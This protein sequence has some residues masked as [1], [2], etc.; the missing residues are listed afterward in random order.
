[1]SSFKLIILSGTAPGLVAFLITSITQGCSQC[2]RINYTR[3]WSWPLSVFCDLAGNEASL[4]SETLR[5]NYN[6]QSFLLWK[7]KF[8]LRYEKL[9]S[10]NTFIPHTWNKIAL[11][12]DF[13]SGS[14]FIT[15]AISYPG[16]KLSRLSS[17]LILYYLCAWLL[18]YLP[19]CTWLSLL[20]IGP[21]KLFFLKI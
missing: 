4:L 9:I 7:R 13:N 3:L 18:K 6:T 14:E 20:T 8:W 2:K 19:F 5:E 11:G 16:S 17:N 1:M 21:K 12:G 10:R 15:M